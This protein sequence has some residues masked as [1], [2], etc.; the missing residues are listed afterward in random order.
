METAAVV[1]VAGVGVGAGFLLTARRMS[2]LPSMIRHRALEGV[3][4]GGGVR[5]RSGWWGVMTLLVA[6]VWV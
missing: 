4:A 2:G 1:M 3:A 6:W 5:E